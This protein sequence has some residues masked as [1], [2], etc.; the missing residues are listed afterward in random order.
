MGAK[1]WYLSCPAVSQIS[2]FTVSSFTANV[3]EKNA[4]PIVD[5]YKFTIKRSINIKRETIPA[6]D[7]G[8]P[9]YSKP[10]IRQIGPSQSA[11]PDYTSQFPHLQEEPD[12]R[13]HGNQ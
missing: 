3:C 1:L 10:G 6:P 8:I 12:I 5:S 2:N 9:V 7:C 4:A 13:N 11:K